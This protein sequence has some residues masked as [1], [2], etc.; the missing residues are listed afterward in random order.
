[1]DIS[2]AI[3]YIFEDRKW[4]MKLFPLLI[5]GV[6]S[7]IPIFG[8]LASVIALGYMTQLARNV[9][10]GAPRP[11][12]TWNNLQQKFQ[13]GG[14][15]FLALIFYNL[16]IILIAVCSTWLISGVG[17]SFLGSTVGI[18]V[19]C[20]TTP[21]LIIYM[22]ITWPMLAMGFTEYIRVGKSGRFYR[23][24]HLWDMIQYHGQ[25]VFRWAIFAFLINVLTGLLLVIPVLGWA[26][27]LLF[28]YPI[29]GHLL[30]QL[31]HKTAVVK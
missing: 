3:S 8:L 30:G 28:V 9:S 5:L 6:I 22:L 27:I 19:L 11:L 20:C 18:F 7:L 10:Q 29:Q 13:L 1:M 12:P 23:P 26:L 4:F 17:S 21:M 31:G 25:Y 16:P 2:R 14:D 24:M 15:V